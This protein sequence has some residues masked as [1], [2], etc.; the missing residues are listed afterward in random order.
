MWLI[1]NLMLLEVLVR[2]WPLPLGFWLGCH[3]QWWAVD[4][5]ANCSL[6]G[7][8]A[9]KYKVGA[10]LYHPLQWLIPID[11]RTSLQPHLLPLPPSSITLGN[12]TL[13]KPDSY[14]KLCCLRWLNEMSFYQQMLFEIEQYKNI[15]MKIFKRGK[16]TRMTPV[17]F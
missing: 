12:K 13:E 6:H 16:I 11:L 14:S 7:Q 3:M 8:K 1:V 15:F 17:F 4:G 10:G 5:R 9:E 2:D